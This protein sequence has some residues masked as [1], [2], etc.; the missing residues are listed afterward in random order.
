MASNSAQAAALFASRCCAKVT[1]GD[2]RPLG[3]ARARW[4]ICTA[5]RT[6]FRAS[7]RQSAE[8]CPEESRASDHWGR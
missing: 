1:G 5:A 2:A 4:S 7:A 3:E 8:D 6:N